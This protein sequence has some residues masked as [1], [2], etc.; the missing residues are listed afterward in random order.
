MSG[1][2]RNNFDGRQWREKVIRT[3]VNAALADLPPL[4]AS[5]A[6]TRNISARLPF[7]SRNATKRNALDKRVTHSGRQR[8]SRKSLRSQRRQ[9]LNPNHI[10]FQ[11]IPNGRRCKG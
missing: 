3:R 9:K 2:A 5:F 6:M 8:R 11:K 4:N 1:G 10:S 7:M